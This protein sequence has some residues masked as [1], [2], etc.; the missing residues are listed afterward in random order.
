MIHLVPEKITLVHSRLHQCLKHTHRQWVVSPQCG[1][2]HKKDVERDT[3]KRT[4]PYKNCHL[5][6]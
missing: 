3:Q 1:K 6:S 4:K 2:C 5:I